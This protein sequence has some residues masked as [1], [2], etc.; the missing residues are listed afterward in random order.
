LKVLSPI[1]HI[2]RSL[3]E[4]SCMGHSDYVPSAIIY[5]GILTIVCSAAA[6]F[7]G[8]VRKRGRA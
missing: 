2:N 7:A 3:V 5:C 8:A 4:L 1:Y 6:I